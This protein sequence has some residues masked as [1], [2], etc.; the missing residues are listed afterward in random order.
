MPQTVPPRITSATRHKLTSASH[1]QRDEHGDPGQ[2]IDTAAS[3]APRSALYVHRSTFRSLTVHAGLY[4]LLVENS[5][6]YLDLVQV[7]IAN[8]TRLAEVQ[9]EG[10]LGRTWNASAPMPPVEERYREKDGQLTGCHF[11]VRQGDCARAAQGAAQGAAQRAAQE[12]AR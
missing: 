8:W 7:T 4:E 3:H 1:Q 11:D 5:D 10:L 12:A 9:P 6:H 2:G